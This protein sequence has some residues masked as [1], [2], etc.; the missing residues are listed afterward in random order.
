MDRLT[1]RRYV[2]RT[3]EFLLS[4]KNR[5]FLVFLFSLLLSSVFWLLKTL[6]ETYET[7]ITVPLQLANVPS[8][9]VITTDLPEELSV[10]VK[11]KG[12]VLMNYLYGPSFSPVQ[13]DFA[14]YED[15]R[16][17]GRVQLMPADIQ[18]NIYAQLLTSSRIVSVKPDTLEF[19][20]NRGMYKKVPVRLSG[21][22]ETTPSYYL[23][24][25]TFSPDS[26]DV[27]APASILDTISA[28]YTQP[29]TFNNLSSDRSDTLA[30]SHVRGA[31]FV[32][33]SVAVLMD[34]DI[35]TEKTVE[36][37]V[38]CI[39][40]PASKDLRTFPSSVKITFRVGAALFKSIRAEDFVLAVTYEDI[41]KNSN[42]SKLPLSLK[43]V[44]A[45]VS[46]V[47]IEPAEVDYLIEEVDEE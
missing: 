43:S 21:V 34:V 32:P 40:F 17:S 25:I 12:T 1:A 42:S 38:G 33:S 20:F 16:L 3:K 29:V 28:A 7:E 30:I 11:D 23:A 18:R 10:T 31:K 9:I 41:L 45:G 2:I 4:K 24:G 36:V 37:P 19:F 44:P 26:V 13:V 22:V 39:N 27:Y 47:R 8:E 35:Y 15:N 6:N 14:K 46:N 5:D